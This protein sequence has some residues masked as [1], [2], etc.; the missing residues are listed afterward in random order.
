MPV[1]IAPETNVEL[2]QVRVVGTLLS[3]EARATFTSYTI[4]DGTGVLTCKKW[5]N[6]DGEDGG[7][8]DGGAAV[9]DGIV[10]GSYV[11][12]HGT[13]RMFN[14]S[15]NVMCLTVEP[16]TDF[17]ELTSHYL[18]CIHVHLE[19]KHGKRGAGAGPAPVGSA[20]AAGVAFGGGMNMNMS[21]QGA[22]ISAG[23]GNDGGI[24][25]QYKVVHDY[26][27]L[28]GTTDQG[29]HI[30][31]VCEGLAGQGFNNQTVRAAVDFLASEGHLYTTLDDNHF[32]STS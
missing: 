7:G 3:K 23:G 2:D 8:G 25:A 21:G 10:E 12:I 32:K 19:R 20:G 17:N 14:E 28:I 29:A 15:K 18:Q 6:Q 30:D 27:M 22:A 26:V 11:R 5:S 9:D 13:V 1:A 4:E 24:P 31:Q 16:I